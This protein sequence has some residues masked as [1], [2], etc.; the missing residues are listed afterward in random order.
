M[1]APFFGQGFNR[2]PA[3]RDE[4]NSKNR[5]LGRESDNSELCFR[6]SIIIWKLKLLHMCVHVHA[7]VCVHRHAHVSV[8]THTHKGC[9]KTPK[10]HQ[11]F[12]SQVIPYGLYQFTSSSGMISATKCQDSTYLGERY[13][14]CINWSI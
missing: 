12:N 11:F 2:C 7:S 5:I 6:L 14:L 4:L 9:L 3:G 13:L 10:F 8:Y 1:N